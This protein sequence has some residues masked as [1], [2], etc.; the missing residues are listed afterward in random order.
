VGAVLTAGKL[1]QTSAKQG[2]ISDI[3]KEKFTVR[4]DGI[5]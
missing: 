2:N 4:D 5:W 3:S 1:E